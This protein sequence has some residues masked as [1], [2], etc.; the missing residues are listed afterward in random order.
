MREKYI[1][2]HWHTHTYT[3]IYISGGKAEYEIADLNPLIQL[4]P[5]VCG[6]IREAA[7][8]T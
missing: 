3:H 6:T 2:I 7:G 4:S 1:Y 8:G 5:G